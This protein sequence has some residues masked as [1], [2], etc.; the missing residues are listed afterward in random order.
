MLQR[1]RR[2]RRATASSCSTTRDA[3]YPAPGPDGVR[4]SD[5]DGAI[6]RP[7]TALQRGFALEAGATADVPADTLTVTLFTEEQGPDPGQLAA[8]VNARLDEALAKAKT[9]PLIEARSGN[10]RT[11]AIYDRANQITGWRIRADVILREPRFQ[12]GRSA[13]RVVAASVEAIVDDL[14]AVARRTRIHG[15]EAHDRGAREIP[16]EG[17]AP[18]PRHWVFPATR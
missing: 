14:F 9:Q 8:K 15:G 1:H 3:T 2:A 18:S 5:G 16:G 6:D 4:R 11:N 12:S 10:Y 7:T 13:R 17:P